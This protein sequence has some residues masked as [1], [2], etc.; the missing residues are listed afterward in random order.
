VEVAKAAAEVANAAVKQGANAPAKRAA[1]QRHKLEVQK[2]R[3]A[4]GTEEKKNDDNQKRRDARG[5]WTEDQ[6]ETR[7][8]Q[9][10]PSDDRQYA[11][12]IAAREAARAR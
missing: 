5:D 3:R 12:R 11:R 10:K 2:E 6:K 9:R 4:G 8:V 1:Q 7:R